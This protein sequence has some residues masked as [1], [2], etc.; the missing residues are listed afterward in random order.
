M[1]MEDQRHHHGQPQSGGSSTSAAFF[2]LDIVDG[3]V[4]NLPNTQKRQSPVTFSDFPD[5]LV[6]SS[7]SE[8]ND[9]TMS[10]ATADDKPQH[11]TSRAQSMSSHPSFEVEEDITA[12]CL[13]EG[14]EHTTSTNGDDATTSKEI[15]PSASTE[16]ARSKSLLRESVQMGISRRT[17]FPLVSSKT[18]LLI[19]DVQTY[20]CDSTEP[21]YASKAL[22]QMLSNISQ[23]LQVVRTN[24]RN[25]C[26]DHHPSS[27]G[28][29]VIFTMIQS[30][31]EDGRD[32]SLDYK[33]SGPYFQ[34][35]PKVCA[36]H[37]ELFLPQAMPQTDDI[38]I[39]KTS[40]SVFMST[41]LDYVLRNLS[42]EQLI[43]C[44]QL[45]EQCVESAVRDA[46]DL[47]YFV[48][49][50]EDACAT[51]SP[52]RHARGL[53][54]M[55]GFCR[56]CSTA[57]VR[58]ELCDS[59][60][61]EGLSFNGDVALRNN[62]TGIDATDNDNSSGDPQRDVESSSSYMTPGMPMVTAITSPTKRRIP[63]SLPP[64]TPPHLEDG[65]A[66]AILKTL[67]FARVKFLKYLTMDASN[68]I[69]SVVVPI[70]SLKQQGSLNYPLGDLEFQPDPASLQ[71]VSPTTAVMFGTLLQKEEDGLPS[72][73]CT[74][75]LLNRVVRRTYDVPPLS[76]I[77]SCCWRR[78]VML[79]IVMVYF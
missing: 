72:D 4:V 56:I 22:P 53:Q 12:S 38:V 32:L 9:K 70:D 75:H 26:C 61:H 43:I 55:K 49:V 1:T 71:F 10:Q 31:T 13:S 58:K 57:Q 16:T 14:C 68:A 54:G 64:V 42:I 47:G 51:Y 35:V 50:V 8:I 65:P 69:Q 28:N 5:V 46:A 37:E 73:H 23:L 52:E 11:Q 3:N 6:S 78:M 27:G 2:H 74:R 44:G 67:S 63:L 33:L 24:R 19:I 76:D 41:N 77:V 7:S 48:T 59:A 66:L 45:T 21:Y 60:S 79:L 40:C 15:P 34:T 62:N 20:C 17:D 36:T 39:P 25:S 30:Q 29:E 18:A